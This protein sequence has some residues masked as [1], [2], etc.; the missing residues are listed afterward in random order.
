MGVDAI[1][2]ALPLAGASAGGPYG[3]RLRLALPLDQIHPAAG[4]YAALTNL[5]LHFPRKALAATGCPGPPQ[6]FAAA[7]QL[8]IIRTGD[9]AIPPTAHTAARC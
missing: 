9:T 8:Y 1:G 2:T 3:T 7:T 6:A 4:V 5:T